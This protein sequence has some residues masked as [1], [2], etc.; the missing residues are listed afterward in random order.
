MEYPGIL[1]KQQH[2]EFP[3]VNLKRCGFFGVV[4]KK[5]YEVSKGLGFYPWIFQAVQH[6]FAE[7]PGVNSKGFTKALFCLGFPGVN[8]IR[9]L[10]IPGFFSK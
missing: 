9:S 7:F 4:K 5:R 8:K 6:N 1:Q 3:W 10:K 2:M